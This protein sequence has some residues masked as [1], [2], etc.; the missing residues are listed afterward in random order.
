MQC[1]SCHREWDRRTGAQAAYKAVAKA[2]LCGDLP[3]AS[4]CQ[5]ADCG[6]PA[7]DYDHR[8]YSKPLEVQP[9]CRSCNKLRGPAI[10][11]APDLKQAA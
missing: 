7:M 11:S 3:R 5:C 9:V 2:I 8:D 10:Q 1:F 4:D 6:L